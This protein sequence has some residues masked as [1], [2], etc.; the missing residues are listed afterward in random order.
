MYSDV[1]DRKFFIP[2]LIAAGIC[3]F[4][5]RG[6][7]SFFFLIPLG[8]LIFRYNNKTACLAFAITFTGRIAFSLFAY[9]VPATGLVWDLVYFTLMTSFFIWINSPPPF[10]SFGIPGTARFIIGSCLGA[11]LFMGIFSRAMALPAFSEEIGA[12]INSLISLNRASDSDVVRNALLD[13][14]SAEMVL[15][16]MKTVMFRGGSLVSCVFIFFFSRQLSLALARLSRREKRDSAL[17]G[18][19]V[20]PVIIWI[21]S[22]SLLLVVLTSVMKIEI[23]E[24]ILWNILILCVILYLAQGL[25]IL[26][27][28]FSRPSMPPFLRIFLMVSLIVVFFSPVLNTVLLAGL[29]ILGIA[30]NW[31]S[32]RAPKSN[33]PPSTPE[34]GDISRE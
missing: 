13:A 34:A 33:G 31:V 25:G 28:F 22:A 21:F 19:H 4:L 9:G 12:M 14:V 2:A 7:L 5:L 18:F 17:A 11:L 32:F 29:V 3:L 16:M 20:Y 10:L 30:E 1:F 27:F 24:I 26:Q 6:F 8:F 15:D 23:P